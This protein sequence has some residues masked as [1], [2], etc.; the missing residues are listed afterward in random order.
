[1][2]A[3][4]KNSR[5]A[6]MIFILLE[7]EIILM[8]IMVFGFS[9]EA[10]Q[11]ATRFSGRLSFVFFSLIILL[12][13]RDS[14]WSRV[15]SEIPY[16]LFATLHGIHLVE[17]LLYVFNSNNTFVPVRLLGGFVAYLLI[18]LMPVFYFLKQRNRLSFK[19]FKRLEIFFGVYVWFIFFMTY[20]PR[21]LGK[22]PHVGGC[23]WEHV[24]FLILALIVGGA[25]IFLYRKYNPA[26]NR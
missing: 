25:G 2:S 5:N 10:L 23:Q 11:T 22:L 14:D 18:F 8:A 7:F 4:S 16:L 26:H 19:T 6:F 9:L 3:I 20:L 1:M 21:V 13:H 15:I 24:T 17:L 12:N